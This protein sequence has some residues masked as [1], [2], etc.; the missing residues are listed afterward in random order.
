M[1]PQVCCLPRASISGNSIPF[2]HSSYQKA[3]GTGWSQCV[4]WPCPCWD[5]PA[6][7]GSDSASLSW[8]SPQQGQSHPADK[9][10]YISGARGQPHSRAHPGRQARGADAVPSGNPGTAEGSTCPGPSSAGQGHHPLR[11]SGTLILC[12]SHG[13]RRWPSSRL[14]SPNLQPSCIT[15]AML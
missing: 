3:G 1:L 7:P 5:I 11:R 9:G 13:A 10:W 8:M 6:H 14:T 15:W 2:T 12:L 4:F